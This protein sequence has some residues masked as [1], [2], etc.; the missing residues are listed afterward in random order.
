MNIKTIQMTHEGSRNYRNFSVGGV[1]PNSQHFGPFL[2]VLL[3]TRTLESAAVIIH[4]Q[5]LYAILN[6]LKFS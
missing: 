2:S 3:T 1:T 5:Y 6:I 4:V